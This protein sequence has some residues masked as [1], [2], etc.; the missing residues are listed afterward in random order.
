[1]K[2]NLA[3]GAPP[4]FAELT[5]FDR[6]QY[7]TA[8][9]TGYNPPGSPPSKIEGRLYIRRIDADDVREVVTGSA[10]L[11]GAGPPGLPASAAAEI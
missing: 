2:A 6:S 8:P 3:P 9:M 7:L 1:L 4:I 10:Q 5:T 11:P